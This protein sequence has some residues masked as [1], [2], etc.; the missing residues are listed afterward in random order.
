MGS[1]APQPPP[2]EYQVGDIVIAAVDIHKRRDDYSLELI[3]AK[4]S[5]LRIVTVSETYGT[6]KVF[7]ETGFAW[8]TFPVFPDEI[9]KPPRPTSP[10]PPRA[11]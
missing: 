8:K 1:K 7:K 11:K 5:R 9:T 10:P 6:Y 2:P 4:G 3:A